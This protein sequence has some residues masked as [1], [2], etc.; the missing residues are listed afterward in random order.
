MAVVQ[1]SDVVIPAVYTSYSA[2]DN[3][4]NSAFVQSGVVARNALL[5]QMADGPSDQF[6]VPY[7]KD[8]DQTVEVNY[9]NDDPADIAVPQKIGTGQW[10]A[11]KAYVNQGWSSM[12][13]VNE[14]LG[15]NPMQRIRNRTGTYFQRQ[16]NRRILAIAKGIVADNI[17]G[18]SGD[19]G[20]DVSIAAGLSAVAA[21]LISRDTFV[22]AAYTL[23]DQVENL[24]VLAVHSVVMARLVKNQ[25]IDFKEDSVGGLT[26]PTYL[27][28]R[29]VIDD[30]LPVVAGGT[31]GFVYTS[32][33]FGS[34]FIGFGKGTPTVPVAVHRDEATGNGGGQ[35]TLWERNTWLLH[36]FGYQWVEGSLAEKSPTLADLALA[37]H[38]TRVLTRKDI[39]FAWIKTNG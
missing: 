9:S 15:Q 37:T 39:P 8:L 6:T 13:L 17:A 11:R 22:N 29:V 24:T 35:E 23:G 3:I 28:R 16:Y 5:D 33:L 38:W 4:E 1:L 36:P 21:N 20:I 27:G 34:G 18:N 25:D 19:M 12:D 30:T 14:L 32:M 7:W 2:V 26:V 31:N 10:N